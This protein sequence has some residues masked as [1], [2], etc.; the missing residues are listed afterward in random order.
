VADADAILKSSYKTIHHVRAPAATAHSFEAVPPGIDSESSVAG[1]PTRTLGYF[2][3]Q[4][5][6]AR[7]F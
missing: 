2:G 1:Q 4:L 3:A 6:A 7:S 5:L